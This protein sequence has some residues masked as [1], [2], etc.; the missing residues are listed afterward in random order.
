MQMRSNIRNTD[1]TFTLSKCILLACALLSL[2]ACQ[3]M[4]SFSEASKG[5][6]EKVLKPY[7]PDVVQGN[8]ISKEQLDLLKIGMSFEDVFVVMGTPLHLNIMRQN[9]ADYISIYK[10]GD[11]KILYQ[12]VVSLYFEDLKLIKI[13]ADIMPT[14]HELIAEIDDIKSS[15]R[16]QRK[17]VAPEL[18]SQ[19]AAPTVQTIPN[20]TQGIGVPRGDTRH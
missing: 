18:E 14:E 8:F 15:R 12:R 16:P 4:T 6:L 7:R 17:A 1:I 13:E 9:R 20:P 2:T 3:G 5:K 19:H 11:D 10:K